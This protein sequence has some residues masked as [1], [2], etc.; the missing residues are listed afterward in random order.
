MIGAD[1]TLRLPAAR[2]A[3][4]AIGLVSLAVLCL[5][6]FFDPRRPLLAYLIGYVF[7]SDV[8][9][10]LLGL[11]MLQHL[12]R[13]EWGRSLRPVLDA[14]AGTFPL[15]AVLLLPI[16]A[17]LGRD[18]R[19]ARPCGFRGGVRRGGRSRR[20]LLQRAVVHRARG[21]VLRALVGS[22]RVA[23]TRPTRAAG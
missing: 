11:L 6:A 22:R 12:M 1:R 16:V 17:G 8:A 10:G 15:L 13:S 23:A 18:L 7:W 19:L 3:A 20:A 4:R 21:G 14:A 9:I 2:S 5:P